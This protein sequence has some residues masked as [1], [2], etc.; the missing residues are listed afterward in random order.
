MTTLKFFL[1]LALAL[2]FYVTF[3]ETKAKK[4]NKKKNNKKDGKII[5][6]PYFS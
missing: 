3:V 1:F 4:T 6:N 5:K 2:I